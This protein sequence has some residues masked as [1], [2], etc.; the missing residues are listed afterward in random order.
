MSVP[1]MDAFAVTCGQVRRHL[2]HPQPVLFPQL[3]HV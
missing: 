3:E 2:H 1:A